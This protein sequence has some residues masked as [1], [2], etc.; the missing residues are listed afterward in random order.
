M[1]MRCLLF[2]PTTS[3]RAARSRP[4]WSAESIVA[5]AASRCFFISASFAFFSLARVTACPMPDN[6]E[7]EADDAEEEEDGAVV[8]LTCSFAV[9][10]L[11]V[12]PPSF[13]PLLLFVPFTRPV[14]LIFF[15]IFFFIS[16]FD[17]VLSPA[18]GLPPL[19]PAPFRP[20][21]SASS[22]PFTVFIVIA[23]VAPASPVAVA[24][25]GVPVPVVLSTSTVK[26]ASPTPPPY[27]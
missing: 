17:C 18:P 27:S 4:A 24:T 5:N 12:G 2:L 19:A 26:V 3:R 16:V 14:F 8:L 6:D 22:G 13:D 15:F 23:P 7:D 1:R 20:R 21:P 10:F 9:P 25:A 11:T